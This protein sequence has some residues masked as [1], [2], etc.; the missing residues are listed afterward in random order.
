MGN[1]TLC[2]C[3]I[4]MQFSVSLVALSSQYHPRR[5]LPVVMGTMLLL[6]GIVLL[7]HIADE[8]DVSAVHEAPII[9]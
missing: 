2:A 3:V 7:L 5:P 9:P 6:V 8:G 1:E 4:S